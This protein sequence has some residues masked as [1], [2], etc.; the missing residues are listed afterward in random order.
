MERMQDRNVLLAATLAV[1]VSIV[2]FFE[3]HTDEPLVVLP[4]LL[5][6]SFV[7]AWI[8]APRFI[9]VGLCLG[10]AII[11]AHAISSA[12]GFVVPR[13][14]KQAPALGDWI[15]MSLLIIPSLL[16]AFGGS[17]VGAIGQPKV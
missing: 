6:V 3:W 17:R 13:Y 7:S 12:T 1:G 2:L 11:I 5:L 4:V 16:A 10:S 8:V 14:Q 9:A 15:V